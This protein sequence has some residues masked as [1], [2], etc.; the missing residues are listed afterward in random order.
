MTEKLNGMGLNPDGE[1]RKKMM[2]V[3]D[4]RI[5]FERLYGV[6]HGETIAALKKIRWDGEN[7]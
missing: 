2:D 1:L 7:D 5:S 3:L 4:R 6:N